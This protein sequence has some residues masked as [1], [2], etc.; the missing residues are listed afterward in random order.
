M[1]YQNLVTK[2]EE[3][4]GWVIVNRPDKLNALN[5][6]TIK[7]L[8][9]AFM[10][11]HEDPEVK[12]VIFTGAGDKAF[13]AGADISELVNL[14]YNRGKDYA[15]EGQE[16]TKLMENLRKPVIAAV[17]GFALG[18]GTEMVLACHIRIASEK[19]KMGQ[20]EVK[21]GLIPGFG[22]TQRLTR[23][24]GKGKALELI[25]TGKIIDAQEALSIGLVNQ[26]VP[27]DKLLDAAKETANEMMKNAPLA[28]EY[29]I[30]VVNQ[31]LDK[32]LE[33]GLLLEAE[34]FG[35][36]CS[37]EDSQEGTK[38]FLEKRKAEFKGI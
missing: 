22:G 32:S 8:Y 9:S 11:F 34:F 33:D 38:A 3:G 4:I 37:T 18:G 28:L 10:S 14:D 21:L 29:S 31:G 19:A 5:A 1:G 36:S 16:L 35:K 24:V 2:K 12:V 6:Q 27:A 15:L 23:L 13:I 17:N 20:P 26:V 7:E 25:L 30:R